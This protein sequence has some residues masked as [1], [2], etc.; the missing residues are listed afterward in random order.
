[1]TLVRGGPHDG[2]TIDAKIT[3]HLVPMAHMVD[4]HLVGVAWYVY[5]SEADTLDFDRYE[6]YS[7]L[8]AL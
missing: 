8:R 3:I 6:D 4:E 2:E 1:M 5:R 7:W